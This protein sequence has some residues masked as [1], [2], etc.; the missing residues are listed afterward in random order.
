[1]LVS[2]ASPSREGLARETTQM[3]VYLV[4]GSSD[5]AEPSRI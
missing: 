1:M 2:R 3:P 4:Y 5:Y